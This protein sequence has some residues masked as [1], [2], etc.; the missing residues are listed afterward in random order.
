MQRSPK[1]LFIKYCTSYSLG[2]RALLHTLQGNFAPRSKHLRDSG[3]P[4]KIFTRAPKHEVP[5][6][7]NTM[8]NGVIDWIE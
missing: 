6:L 4:V 5:P 8:R 7:E 3:P 2:P 1:S